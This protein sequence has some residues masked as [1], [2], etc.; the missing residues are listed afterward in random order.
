[1]T[2]RALAYSGISLIPNYSELSSRSFANTRINFLGR[3]FKLP[4]VPANME[5]VIDVKI[6]KFLSENG[7]FYIMHRFENE[8]FA[9]SEFVLKANR[10]R[11]KLISISTGVNKDSMGVLRSISQHRRDLREDFI[12]I[13]VAHGHHAKMKKAIP[14]VKSLF[15]HAKI[16]AGNVAKPQGV[17]DLHSWGA[18]AIKVGIGSGKICT[19]RYQ[20]GFHVPMF[21]C[22]Q[23]C[24]NDVFL[25]GNVVRMKD[26]IPL[27]ADGGVEHPG[28]IAKALVSGAS[29]VMAGS[30]F[31]ACLDSPAKVVDG[32]KQYRGS[33]S[34]E[35][36]KSKHHVEGKM[37]E[38]ESGTSYADRLEEITEALQ[39][40][41]S[42]AGGHDL[43][44]F[45]N[46][47]YIEV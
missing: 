3:T 27:I 29:M 8:E 46:V 15:P 39:S 20:T 11:W 31:A 23:T 6:A 14:R 43:S 36:R 13:D 4:V 2:E 47:E 19:T 45:Q 33:T 34:Y 38:I 22:V 16:I 17:L 7:Y 1:M 44:S 10:E 40:S 21:T 28:D 12:T 9:I 41:I 18:D 25:D 32:K 26:P 24:A 5:D 42:Y 30:L 37:L 35:A